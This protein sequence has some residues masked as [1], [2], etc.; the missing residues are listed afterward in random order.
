MSGAWSRRLWAGGVG[1]A[2]LAG[3]GLAQTLPLPGASAQQQESRYAVEHAT[4]APEG[5]AGLQS[6]SEELASVAERVKARV[7]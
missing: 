2:F 5:A 1:V 3:I 6:L 4:A 7:V